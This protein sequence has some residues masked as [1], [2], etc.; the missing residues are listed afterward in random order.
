MYNHTVKDYDGYLAKDQTVPQNDTADGNGGGLKLSGTMGGIEVVA[1]VGSVKL[2]LAD[3]KVMTIKL[4]QSS[5]DGDADAY[6]DL[7]TLYTVTAA[8][9]TSVAIGT[10]LGRFVIPS[11]AE[12]YI[13]ATITNDDI[14]ATGKVEIY[15]H[16]LPR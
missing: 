15:P 6:T 14:A 5:D 3:T 2:D 8:G 11:N 4:Q 12:T 7:H 10:E 13:K 9:A 1:V 16:Y